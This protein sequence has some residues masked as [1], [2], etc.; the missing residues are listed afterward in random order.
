MTEF[1]TA[2]VRTWLA[3]NYKQAQFLIVWL[4]LFSWAFLIHAISSSFVV[5]AIVFIITIFSSLRIDIG[6]CKSRWRERA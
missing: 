3:M 1:T 6:V 5:L 2:L 4:S